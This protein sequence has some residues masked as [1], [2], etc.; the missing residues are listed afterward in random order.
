MRDNYATDIFQLHRLEI[1]IWNSFLFQNKYIACLYTLILIPIIYSISLEFVYRHIFKNH[2][3]L[4]YFLYCII[5]LTIYYLLRFFL[6]RYSIIKKSALYFYDVSL[7]SFVLRSFFLKLES[8]KFLFYESLHHKRTGNPRSNQLAQYLCFFLIYEY[9]NIF[10]V[11]YFWPEIIVLF[12]LILYANIAPNQLK[13]YIYFLFIIITCI[14]IYR[15]N[16]YILL[17]YECKNLAL[18]IKPATI[19][20]KV[21]PILVKYL[22]GHFGKIWKNFIDIIR[23]YIGLLK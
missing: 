9:G 6:S 7:E 3:Y 17:I 21:N 1:D 13:L 15:L 5:V 20:L 11:I 19:E 10:S 18:S 22:F 14:L 8:K 16:K 2:S 23:V 4:S 12:F